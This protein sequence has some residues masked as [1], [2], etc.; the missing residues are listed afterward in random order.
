MVVGAAQ[1]LDHADQLAHGLAA[2]LLLV[3][4]WPDG[5]YER[6]V[7]RLVGE[8]RPRQEGREAPTALKADDAA[9]G[10]VADRLER[11]LVTM[12]LQCPETLPE[13]ERCGLVD[14]ME[15]AGH[16][17]LAQ[18][19][20]DLARRGS[21]TTADLLA[22]VDDSRRRRVITALALQ[23]DPWTSRACRGL[24]RQFVERQ[25]RRRRSR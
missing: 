14:L 5:A 10:A 1:G 16:Q 11:Q 6:W 7:R 24:I 2:K 25:G 19:I 18:A 15:D 4:R 12:M 21:F 23:T 20:L 3:G 9:G 22:A 13:V 17:A 8:R